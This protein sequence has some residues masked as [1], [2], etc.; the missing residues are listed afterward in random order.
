MTVL[1]QATNHVSAHATK[2]D[3]QQIHN[4]SMVYSE[5]SLPPR[6]YAVAS[7]V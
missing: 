7:E 2:S 4:A 3:E 5:T 1:G 6:A